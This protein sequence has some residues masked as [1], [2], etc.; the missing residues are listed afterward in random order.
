ML[1]GGFK[2]KGYETST[3]GGFLSETTLLMLGEYTIS[4][5]EIN[6]ISVHLPN[7]VGSINMHL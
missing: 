1:F 7:I 5:T 2:L 3:H 6:S 4:A